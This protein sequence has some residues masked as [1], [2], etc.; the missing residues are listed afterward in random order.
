MKIIYNPAAINC[1]YGSAFLDD[2]GSF[3]LD[4]KNIGKTL[5]SLD[6]ATLRAFEKKLFTSMEKQPVAN[7]RDI[8]ALAI[9]KVE[10]NLAERQ[11]MKRKGGFEICLDTRFIHIDRLTSGSRIERVEYGVAKMLA[12]GATPAVTEKEALIIFQQAVLLPRQGK[13]DSKALAQALNLLLMGNKSYLACRDEK[14]VS[15]IG[16]Y[17]MG[18]LA[19]II[20]PPLL[21]K[22]ADIRLV[23]AELIGFGII[24]IAGA[25]RISSYLRKEK[26]MNGIIAKGAEAIQHLS[27]PLE[28]KKKS[29]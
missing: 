15:T 18:I 21:A 19:G 9:K 1:K 20:M 24:A 17:G 22:V 4:K 7:N 8:R 14:L 28:G 16:A 23:L 12:S 26:E 10:V 11:N 25:L 5:D 6:T 29:N 2:R 27:S 13:E 3:L